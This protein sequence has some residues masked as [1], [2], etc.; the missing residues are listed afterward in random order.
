MTPPVAWAQ[1][2]AIASLI[3]L[4][5]CTVAIASLIK[6]VAIASLIVTSF[7]AQSQA[8]QHLHRI[9]SSSAALQL[10]RRLRSTLLQKG[11]TRVPQGPMGAL[12]PR[13][14]PGPLEPY[15][16]PPLILAPDLKVV[17]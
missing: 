6:L 8:C 5:D 4:V 16:G 13:G 17:P 10:Q 9:V 15:G 3:T 12:T 1:G 14:S 2:A 7:L 11:R